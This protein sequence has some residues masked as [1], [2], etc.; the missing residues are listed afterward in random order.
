MRFDVLLTAVNVGSS[1]TLTE[2][3]M[4]SEVLLTLSF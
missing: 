4:K 2:D 3:V 1:V